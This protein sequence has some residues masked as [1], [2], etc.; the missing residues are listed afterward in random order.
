MA[1]QNKKELSATRSKELIGILKKRF[2]KN[3]NPDHVSMVALNGKPGLT[4]TFI[5]W[6]QTDEVCIIG[7]FFTYLLIPVTTF[8]K[9]TDTC[10]TAAIFDF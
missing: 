10:F 4:I 3:L 9:H 5:T 8:I 1:K 2:E 6:E 7:I